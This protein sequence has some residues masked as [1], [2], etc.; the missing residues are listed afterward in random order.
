MSALPCT[1]VSCLLSRRLILR[2]LVAFAA[3]VFVP[4][5][6]CQERRL[7]PFSTDFRGVSAV[8]V[9][10]GKCAAVCAVA[11]EQTSVSHPVLPPKFMPRA[12]RAIVE[13]NDAGAEWQCAGSE[14]RYATE[15]A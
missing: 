11:K 14:T 9:P 3:V 13:R 8:C 2:R 1:Q 5:R 10:R 7:P 4:A 12:T 6:Q 15:G